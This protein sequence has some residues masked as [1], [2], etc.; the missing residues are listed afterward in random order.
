MENLEKI[1]KKVKKSEKDLSAEVTREEYVTVAYQVT[2]HFIGT[3][4]SYVD[5]ESNELRTVTKPDTEKRENARKELQQIYDSS[6]WFGARYIAGKLLHIDQI[7]FNNSLEEWLDDLRIEINLPGK[8]VK[9]YQGIIRYTCDGY[10]SYKNWDVPVYEI[11]SMTTKH[12]ENVKRKN[13]AKKD[14]YYL[15]R[16]AKDEGIKTKITDILGIKSRLGMAYF[17]FINILDR[18]II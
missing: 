18:E 7:L 12:P 4:S 16:F 8:T 15:Y 17:K 3:G 1:I 14:L 9:Y 2:N 11:M 10:N 5:E 6:E 13:I